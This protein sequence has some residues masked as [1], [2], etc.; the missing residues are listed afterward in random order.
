[1]SDRL[2]Q[3]VKNH[4][5]QLRGRTYNLLDELKDEDL[6]KTLPFPESQSL[7]YQLWCMLGSEES[8]IPFI[9]TGSMEEWSCSLDQLERTQISV[10]TIKQHLQAADQRLFEAL[11]SVDLLQRFENGLTPLMNYM[12]LVEHESH[13]HGQLINFIYAH[14]L[15]IPESW[16]KQWALTRS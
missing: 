9:T 10:A 6:S 12:T 7:H 8:W 1:M 11:D 14:Q 5:Q 4:W 16:A 13:H 3:E 2:L 15:P